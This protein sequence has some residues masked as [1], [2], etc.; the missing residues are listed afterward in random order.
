MKTKNPYKY[1]ISGLKNF[2]E[3]RISDVMA[4]SIVALITESKTRIIAR[5]VT[6][7]K[8][9]KMFIFGYAKALYDIDKKKHKK[10]IKT[11][12]KRAE[13]LDFLMVHNFKQK[14]EDKK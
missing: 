5:I 3:S 2:S 12:L 14:L 7:Y 1:N 11:L 8:I 13:Q 6:R 9:R 10:F 4:M